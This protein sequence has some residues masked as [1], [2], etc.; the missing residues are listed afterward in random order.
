MRAVGGD[1]SPPRHIAEP[2]VDD[3]KG[4]ERQAL[5]RARIEFAPEIAVRR[6]D[7]KRMTGRAIERRLAAQFDELLV[8]LMGEA[9]RA[10]AFPSVLRE[11]LTI[12]PPVARIFHACR[13]PLSNTKRHCW[14]A[15]RRKR[16][17]VSAAFM[18]ETSAG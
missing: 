14:E 6:D 15:A 12:R 18:V 8:Q 4:K 3:H 7:R 1:H 2:Q 17:Q 16:P 10:G 11:L 5:P 9:Y 13:R